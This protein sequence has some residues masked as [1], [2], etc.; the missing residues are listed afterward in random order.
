LEGFSQGAIVVTDFI[1]KFLQPGQIHAP[2]AQDCLGVLMY[3][4]PCRSAGSVAPWSV[5]QAGPAANSGLDPLIRL[6]KLGIKLP[7][8]LMDVY[9]KGDIFSDNEPTK[10]GDVKSAVY[11]GVARGDLFS[12]PYSLCAQI[13]DLFTF[14]TFDEVWA[15]FEA[16]IS[17][18]GFLATGN[19]NPHYS[20]FD[21]SGGLNWC[22]NLLS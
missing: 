10:E 12:N 11:Q 22:R 15:I 19:N 2:R 13:A 5:A 17:G 20:P 1:T 3:G 8:P 16:I 4:N 18:I 7:Y 6:D 14:T 9:R 21:I